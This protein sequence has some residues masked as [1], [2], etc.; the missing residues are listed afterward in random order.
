MNSN[1]ETFASYLN[2]IG[3]H[4]TLGKLRTV[5]KDFESKFLFYYFA[6]PSCD[7]ADLSAEDLL[8]QDALGVSQLKL[9]LGASMQITM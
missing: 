2:V 8:A 3:H 4:E 6:S 7:A 9:L 5:L 1:R